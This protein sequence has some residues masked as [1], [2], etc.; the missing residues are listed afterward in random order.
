MKF[1]LARTSRHLVTDERPFIGQQ[2]IENPQRAILP[3]PLMAEL[4]SVRE[5]ER[6]VGRPYPRWMQITSRQ[7]QKTWRHYG[8]YCLLV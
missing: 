3:I 5:T 2:L 7:P 8:H 6:I 4:F 1:Q